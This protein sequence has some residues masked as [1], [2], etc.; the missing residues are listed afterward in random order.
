MSSTSSPVPQLS[1]AGPY[2]F[3]ITPPCMS[4]RR[5]VTF[6]ARTTMLAPFVKRTSSTTAPSVVTVRSVERVVAG[7]QPAGV[8]VVAGFGNWSSPGD[9]LPTSNECVTAAIR[10]RASVT[11]S[12]GVL[13]PVVWYVKLGF[14]VVAKIW[15]PLP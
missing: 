9:E 3:V 14:A 12:R 13:V 4:T 1:G 5:I 11:R 15:V 10:P 2:W 7:V 8:P 6:L